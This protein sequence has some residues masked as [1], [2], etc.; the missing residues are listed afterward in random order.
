MLSYEQ[1]KSQAAGLEEYVDATPNRRFRTITNA[2]P[3]GSSVLDIACG[4]GTQ[5][6]TLAAKGCRVR[7]VDIAPGAVALAKAK[8]LNVTLADADRFTSDSSVEKILLADYDFVIFSKCLAYLKN[9]NALMRALN[10]RN[11]IVNQRN[12]SYWRSK[13]SNIRGTA[14]ESIIENLPYVS[15]EGLSIPQTSLC[16][17][18]EW[19]ESYGF[20]SRVLLGNFFRSRD[21]VT[22][23]Y[24]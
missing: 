12:P 16:A 2:I 6:Q 14:P 22:L 3:S 23:F 8:G 10:T 21:A 15:A 7:G 13:L 1:F 9:K 4:S 11:V 19:G 5:L 17:L 18:R 24:R 20:K